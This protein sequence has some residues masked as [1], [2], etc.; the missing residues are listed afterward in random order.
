MTTPGR[1]TAGAAC[2][3]VVAVAI[4]FVVLR[5]G[6]WE[7]EDD[8]PAGTSEASNAA[9]PAAP[10]N[11]VTNGDG[12]EVIRQPESATAPG[13]PRPRRTG[14]ASSDSLVGATL[15]RTASRQGA[16]VAGFPVSVVP[17]LPGSAV[18]SSGVSSTRDS[19][20]VSIVANSSKSSEAVL[21]FYRRALADHD[22]VESVAPAVAGAVAAGYRRG[23]DHLVVTSSTGTG[24]TSYSVF[25][26][27]HADAH[28]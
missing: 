8:G 3:A 24:R 9:S 23:A 18:G 2:V 11:G 7:A 12:S 4:A 19:V 10:D 1:R 26:T 28:E 14:A 5:A 15:P 27:L 22:F 21:A 6:A 20:Q 25:G 13:L 17:V 16:L